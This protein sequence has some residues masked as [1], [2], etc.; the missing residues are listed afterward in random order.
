MSS[1][2]R[3]TRPSQSASDLTP[4]ERG[5]VA[6]GELSLVAAEKVATL[7]HA[8]ARDARTCQQLGEQAHAIDG[9]LSTSM[10]TVESG[11]ITAT[12][13]GDYNASEDGPSSAGSP[14]ARRRWRHSP[15]RNKMA[16]GMAVITLCGSLVGSGYLVIHHRATGQERRRA[17][18]FAA[19]A[20]QQA[21]ALMAIDAGQARKDV[22]R[23]I[24]ASTGQFKVGMLLGAQD[25]VR[26]MEQSHTSTQVVVEG[27]AVES[28]TSDSAVVLVAAKTEATSADDHKRS[29]HR[30][31]IVMTLQ[32]DGEQAKIAAIEVLP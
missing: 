23:I 27:V 10:N 14:R 19:A 15:S 1:W 32:K 31:R 9:D 12:A 7:A 6:D 21:V 28:M 5:K 30:W 29:P 26:S 2:E 16:L 8:R 22:Q 20:R 17:L 13:I 25:L 11:H 4:P 24:D 18:D 3:L